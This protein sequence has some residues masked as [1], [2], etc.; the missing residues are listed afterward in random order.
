MRVLSE[1]EG[2]DFKTQ[3]LAIEVEP[4][5]EIAASLSIPSAR[6]RKHAVLVVNGDA[7]A[8]TQLARRGAVV[9]SLA[10]RASTAPS[11]GLAGDWVTDTRAWLIG[12]NLPGMRAADIIRGVDLLIARPDVNAAAISAAAHDVAGV[13]LLMAAALDP[14]I[15]KIWLHRTPYSLRAAL[16]GPLNRNLHD[17]LIPGFALKW[18]LADMKQ[19]LGPRPL[20][21]TDP[22]DWMGKVAPNVDGCIYRT[23]EQP[24]DRFWEM[25]LQ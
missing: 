16:D 20:I 3:R 17:A 15:G 9:L 18:D 2:V 12:R 21:W 10:P 7:N 11:R 8:A 14:R 13:W 25:L 6:G 23:F 24:D 5:L 4:G 1:S 22:T 19:A